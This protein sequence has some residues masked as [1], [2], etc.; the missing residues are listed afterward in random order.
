MGWD[1]MYSL[2]IVVLDGLGYDVV[3]SI[4]S[5][6]GWV[7][8]GGGEQASTAG[9]YRQMELSFYCDLNQGWENPCFFL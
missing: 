4:Y 8:G 2:F 7:G 6:V 1:M 3:F 9:L 5:G